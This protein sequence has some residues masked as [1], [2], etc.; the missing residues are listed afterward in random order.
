[1]NFLGHCL[2][3]DPSPEALTGSLWPDFGLRPTD[4][5]ST[6][7]LRH[8]DQHQAIDKF[9]DQ[10]DE[11]EPI[12]LRLR[13]IFRK[14]SPIVIDVLI[15][16][17]L[18]KHW[19]SIHDAPLGQF[20]S[21]CYQHLNQFDEFPV[22]QRF[23]QTLF[24]MSEHDWFSAYAEPDGIERALKGMSRRIRFETPLATQAHQACALVSEFDE[25]FSAYLR[26]LSFHLNNQGQ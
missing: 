16:H 8:F 5:A 2:F 19:P 25:N 20:A 15:D 11:L 26:S 14:T 1:M 3:S 13:P 4:N 24:W 9:T 7:F 22:S 23:E 18:A 17:Y 10:C 12:R 6:V 21:N